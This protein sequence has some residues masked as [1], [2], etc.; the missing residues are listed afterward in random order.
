M[1]TL[2]RNGTV[3]G[4]EDAPPRRADVLVDDNGTVEAIGPSLEVVLGG[5]QRKH[6]EPAVDHTERLNDTVEEIHEEPMAGFGDQN[7]LVRRNDDS[8]RAV[9]VNGNVAWRGGTPA[10]DLGTARRY[11][12]FLPLGG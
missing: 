3:I 10:D 5:G 7:R 2:I 9:M 11:G 12:R 6:Q 8:V 4:G 1:S